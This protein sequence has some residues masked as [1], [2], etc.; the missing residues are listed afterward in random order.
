M[1][2]RPK[3]NTPP[4]LQFGRSLVWG[5]LLIMCWG[6]ALL[7]T[8]AL[9]Q[10]PLPIPSTPPLA[11]RPR[12][13]VNLSPTA[14]DIPELLK[15]L[16]DAGIRWV[17]VEVR[18]DEV[19]PRP[20]TYRWHVWDRRLARLQALGLTPVVVLNRSPAWAR[21]P[22]DAANPYAPPANPQDLARFA[23]AFARRYATLVQYYQIWDEPNI[24]P[25]WGNR[26]ADP[27]G[28]LRLLQESALAIRR[29]DPDARI[30]SA[31]LAPTL[32][33][34]RINRNDLAYLEELYALDAA[35][36]FDILAWHPYGFNRPPEDPPAAGRLNF[37][38]VELA[39]N[40]MV[41]Y[42]DADTPIWATAFGWNALPPSQTS[43]WEQ[44]SPT[45]QAAYLYRAYTWA[46]QHA[47]W[48]GPMFWTHAYP[49]APATDPRWGFALW[50]PDTS[51]RAAWGALEKAAKLPRLDVGAHVLPLDTPYPTGTLLPGPS[52]TTHT[53]RFYGTGI[54]LR[55][56]GGPRW[57]TLWATVDGSPPPA[58]R[59][60]ER[61]RA[62][63]NLYRPRP[64]EIE[65]VLA[66]GLPWGPHTLALTSGPGDPAWPLTELV[67]L[68]DTASSPLR[69][70]VLVLALVGVLALA[71]YVVWAWSPGLGHIRGPVAPGIHRALLGATV[72]LIPFT[73]LLVSLGDTLFVLPEITLTLL[74][75]L[76]ALR[77]VWQMPLY[78]FRA[79]LSAPN[80]W[81][82]L[83]GSVVIAALFLSTWF[84]RDRE[85]AFVALRARVLFPFALWLFVRSSNWATRT[86]LP[87]LLVL[88]GAV[89]ALYALTDLLAGR[90]VWV[91]GVPRVRGIFGS[92]NHL[93]L[94][95]VRI[96]PFAVVLAQTHPR[97]WGWSLAPI[98]LAL[99]L[100]GS[101][102]AWMLGIP[103]G[104][105]ALFGRHTQR[106]WRFLPLGGA[107]LGV[108]FF[109]LRGG[110]TWAQRVRIWRGVWR[111]I[112]DSPWVGIGLNQFS[113]VYPAYMLPE[114][115][116]EPL[117]Y[118][119]H[120]T[121]VHTAATLG[122]P[123]TVA[124]AYLLGRALLRPAPD[125]VPRAARASLLGGLAF[126]L[127]D[128]FWA[129]DD[130]AYLT[131]LALALLAPRRTHDA[132]EFGL[133]DDNGYNGPS[134][135]LS[136]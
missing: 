109:L 92:P 99:I 86:H 37:R 89:L 5:L 93:A 13:G 132:R 106:R 114:A 32:D 104:L 2:P 130:L 120:N 1:M 129:L 75:T 110:E 69:R 116:Q 124:L 105:I 66:Q 101:R 33:P 60:D 100:T 36:W 121:F 79:P 51:P 119:A 58:L 6:T 34:G 71:G 126:G 24:A 14:L 125:A 82:V 91:A 8:H 94:V 18:W 46:S 74:L 16:A 77:L 135:T 48:L 35:T 88:G 133:S 95:L 11:L 111:M 27:F 72:L 21:A 41:R 103:V 122:I 25:H 17:R 76:T 56:R 4:Y 52:G 15:Q 112:A 43:P 128:A 90:A 50:N 85:A 57:H 68:G 10:P 136:G 30:L 107:L 9:W 53:F 23:Q 102:G 39:R 127:V 62:Y 117:L 45:D 40:I 80:R 63:I 26:E 118:H 28:Y 70:G 55:A 31:A 115:W 59:R 19:E 47:P 134:T 22:D 67:V 38:R 113:R 84:A 78:P 64:E 20:G 108:G 42:G 7:V 73:T 3:E 12:P 87:H 61:G 49:D 97:R 123:A 98:T 29:E 83:A 131:A 44:V 65:V 96:V 81:D 54:V